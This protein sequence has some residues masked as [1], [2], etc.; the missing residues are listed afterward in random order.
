MVMNYN[1]NHN[2]TQLVAAGPVKLQRWNAATGKAT[3]VKAADW[4]K[5]AW[6]TAGPAVWPLGDRVVVA[7]AR[8]AR[9]GGVRGQVHLW[10]FPGGAVAA[11]TLRLDEWVYG[12]HYSP[13]GNWLAL[14]LGRELLVCDALSLKE[15][16]RVRPRGLKPPRGP[17]RDI[18]GRQ[19]GTLHSA[20]FLGQSRLVVGCCDGTVRLWDTRKWKEQARLRPARGPVR[21]LGFSPDANV[22]MARAGAKVAVW[23]E[24]D[25]E[26]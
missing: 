20:L 23:E 25:W 16:A 19:P 5:T 14:R 7:F 13:C 2:G 22:A 10:D 15:V 18:F 4:P 11:K 24:G 12:L 3:A 26:G 8:S 21:D 6:C 17:R 1:F 9:E